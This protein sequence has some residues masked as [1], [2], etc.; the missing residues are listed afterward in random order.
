MQMAATDALALDAQQRIRRLEA[1]LAALQA[2][3]REFTYTVSHDLRAPLRHIL[4]YVQLVQEDAGPQLAEEV[5]GFLATI[6]DSAAHLGLLMDAL[7]DLSRV[8]TAPVN[9][10]PIALH[11]LVQQTREA[12]QARQPARAIEWR[13]APDLPQ[14]HADPV[15][16]QQALQHILDNAVKFTRHQERACIE[17]F[18]QPVPGAGQVAL[19]V[20]DNGVGY[21]P[22]LQARL[23]QPFQRLHSARQFEGLGMGLAL[24]RKLAQRMGGAVSAEGAAD[25]GCRVRLLLNGAAQATA[26]NEPQR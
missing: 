13:I 20:Q 26:G 24:T 17:V 3:M 15:L 10:T 5:Q 14:V 6:A 2:E 25:A 16:L 9:P 1:E 11:G 21:N 4:S 19:H 22:A 12:L 18:A 7:L 23:F 8:G